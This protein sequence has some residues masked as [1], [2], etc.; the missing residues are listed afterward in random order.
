MDHYNKYLKYKSKYFQLKNQLGGDDICFKNYQS[1]LTEKGTTG[2]TDCWADAGIFLLFG[3]PR[4]R[5][6]ILE[7]NAELKHIFDIM[8]KDNIID[9]E[10]RMALLHY[11]KI[12]EERLTR[13]G[14]PFN[15]IFDDSIQKIIR[16][17][18]R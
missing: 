4:L 16:E 5:N 12:S 1:S 7:N 8:L 6:L 13:E 15:F 2:K 10:M 9:F 11:F 18:Q 17:D 14:D 3:N